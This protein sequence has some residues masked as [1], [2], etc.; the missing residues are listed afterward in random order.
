MDA[1]AAWRQSLDEQRLA[2][3]DLHAQ[4][5]V[6]T[7]NFQEAIDVAGTVVPEDGPREIERAAVHAGT[8]RFGSGGGGVP[9]RPP[10]TAGGSPNRSASSR[11]R[12]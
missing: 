3:A 9:R 11:R 1:L 6:A 4:L 7:E 12:R 10:A 5:A 8:R 2:A